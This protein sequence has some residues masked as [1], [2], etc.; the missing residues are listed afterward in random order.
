MLNSTLKVK[1]FVRFEQ[2]KSMHAWDQDT[3][4]LHAECAG[5]FGNAQE[6]FCSVDHAIAVTGYACSGARFQRV[7]EQLSL[8]QHTQ[9]KALQC[10]Y[11]GMQA[12]A[13]Y[14]P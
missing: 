7:A 14:K 1:A 2:V 11:A 8:H 5:Q 12:R 4:K 3:A 13:M 6:Q 10:L 9:I